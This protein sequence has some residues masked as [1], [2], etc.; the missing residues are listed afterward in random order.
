MEAMLCDEALVF[1]LNGERHTEPKPSVFILFV[2]FL[3]NTPLSVLEGERLRDF[4][5]TKV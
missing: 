4:C 1:G 3:V 2:L 5:P